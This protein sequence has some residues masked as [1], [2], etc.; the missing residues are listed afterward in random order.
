MLG[1]GFSAS[2]PIELVGAH[3]E[4]DLD[5]DGG[6]FGN[7]E[8]S[9]DARRIN[10]TGSARFGVW[11]GD[12][13]EPVK[14]EA[15]G[16]LDLD[17]GQ[18]GGS[19][20]CRGGRF[21]AG[22][23]AA[24][25]RVGGDA[26][27]GVWQVG[28]AEPV[29]FEALGPVNLDNAQL[30]GELD[31]DGGGF[32]AVSAAAVRVGRDARFGVWQVGEAE[33]VRFYAQSLVDLANAQV[34]GN[35]DCS[36]GQFDAVSIA[37]VRVGGDTKFGVWQAGEAEPVRFEAQNLVYMHNAQLG[38]DLDCDGG[39]FFG[40]PIA[41]SATGVKVTRSVWLSV[42]GG[43]FE[44]KGMVRLRDAEIAGSLICRGGSFSAGL[45]A[46]G[47]TVIASAELNVWHDAGAE[48]VRF[49][50]EGPVW[51]SNAKI[52]NELDCRGGKFEADLIMAGAWVGGDVRLGVWQGGEATPVRFEAQGL[53]NLANAHINGELDCS[54]GCFAN[55]DM[56][57]D[58]RRAD[59]TGT[60]RFGLW[61]REEAESFR[62][63][64]SGL[65][66][67]LRAQIGG[68]LY[69]SGGDFAGTSV[70]LSADQAK[71][72][73][74]IWLNEEGNH[75]FRAAGVVELDDAEIAGDLRCKGQ[76]QGEEVAL[77]GIG[78]SV[79]HIFEW[80]PKEFCGI[81]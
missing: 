9:L 47:V 14:F 20:D 8:I 52:A 43:R 38:G 10:L 68:E 62:F 1:R 27:L 6:R 45:N 63:H 48:S 81:G 35:L 31:C 73:R 70:S 34:H 59:M 80:R 17:N 13:S 58:A 79:G 56:A 5:C 18:L 44:A 41:L 24:G 65:V 71:I 36:G 61:Q 75:P 51:L 78:M 39:G 55:T 50:A 16:L 53:V 29:R 22:L 66:Y 19:V 21:A 42:E 72:A 74:S 25:A 28:E 23:S 60:V 77:T 33:P 54:G 67:L 3:I 7:D 12:E 26:R 32:A 46:T 49:E 64:A 11:Q 30:D 15:Q 69:C 37:A 2:G 4:G 76:F 40:S 57:L